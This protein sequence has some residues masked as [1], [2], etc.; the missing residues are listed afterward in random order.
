[1]RKGDFFMKKLLQKCLPD[2]IFSHKI[3]HGL[4][5]ALFVCL[6]VVVVSQVGLQSAATRTYFT[7]I[8]SAEGMEAAGT[9]AEAGTI[10]LTLA[11]GLPGADVELLVNG[12]A[13]GTF[14]TPQKTL[15]VQTNSTVEVRAKGAVTVHI[16]GV[17]DNL[18]LVTRLTE[19][20]ADGGCKPVCRVHFK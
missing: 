8:E 13:A 12:E 18:R 4:F 2:A 10:S 9:G 11:E 15:T 14:D 16:D 19:V 1:M 20:R 6:G 5:V 7:D 3:Q 17:S